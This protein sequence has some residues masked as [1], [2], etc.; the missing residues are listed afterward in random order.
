[1]AVSTWP[2]TVNEFLFSNECTVLHKISFSLHLSPLIVSLARTCFCILSL[3]S[4]FL[5]NDCQ[6]QVDM[7]HK[8]FDVKKPKQQQPSNP[9]LNTKINFYNKLDMKTN[10]R[11]RVYQ[12]LTKIKLSKTN[13]REM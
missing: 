4:T 5:G 11:L 12:H 9:S 7:V 1:M 6:Q 3:G 8:Q 2:C 10:A 13:K